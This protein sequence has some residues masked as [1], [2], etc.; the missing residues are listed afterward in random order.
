M[1]STPVEI[2]NVNKLTDNYKSA[3]IDIKKAI[4]CSSGARFKEC[5]ALKNISVP[6]QLN[7][8]Y[9]FAHKLTTGRKIYHGTNMSCM[10]SKAFHLVWK[11]YMIEFC[12]Y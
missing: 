4:F 12:N 7:N 10:V 9:K 3:C 5:C 2:L 1:Y 6:E 8:F 11:T